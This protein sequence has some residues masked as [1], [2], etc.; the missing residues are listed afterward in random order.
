MRTVTGPQTRAALGG[1]P[2][3]APRRPHERHSRKRVGW[4]GEVLPQIGFEFVDFVVSKVVNVPMLHDFQ[5][6]M[7][8]GGSMGDRQF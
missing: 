1:P 8:F 6:C 3:R 4:L 5:R 7:M 2:S